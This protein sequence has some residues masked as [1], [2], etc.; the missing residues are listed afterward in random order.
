[1]T[2]QAERIISKFG[3][4]TRLANALGDGYYPSLVSNWRRGRG[5]IPQEHHEAIYQAA[6]R[7]G[8]PLEPSEFSVVK[9]DAA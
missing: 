6:K 9:E 7:E 3:G 4:V 8:I 2:T 1:M 5:F